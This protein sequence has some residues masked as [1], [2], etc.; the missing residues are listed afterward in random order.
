MEKEKTN[1]EVPPKM[2]D[3][4]FQVVVKFQ[5]EQSLFDLRNGH[6]IDFGLLDSV[7]PWRQFRNSIPDIK[8][9]RL[10]TSL[11]TDEINTLVE[12]ARSLDSNYR[13]PNFFLPSKRQ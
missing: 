12:R 7:I 13:P 10:F 5:D 3:F 8:V 11:S 4:F 9:H 1:K 2:R 6:D